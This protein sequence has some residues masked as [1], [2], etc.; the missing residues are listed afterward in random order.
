MDEH[1]WTFVRLLRDPAISRQEVEAQIDGSSVLHWLDTDARTEASEPWFNSGH[2]GLADGLSTPTEEFLRWWLR[3]IQQRLQSDDNSDR[4]SLTGLISRTAFDETMASGRSL[5]W[6]SVGMFDLDHFKQFNDNYGHD[7]GDRVLIEVG[8]EL[9]DWFGTNERLVR[10]GGEEFLVLF[11]D[12]LEDA[13][14]QLE[15]FRDH[16][17]SSTL[18]EDQPRAI[19]FSGGVAPVDETD[20]ET[21]ITHADQ[22]LYESKHLGRNQITR[23]DSSLTNELNY[24]VWGR[25]RYVRSPAVSMALDGTFLNLVSTQRIVRYRWDENRTRSI[26]LP[27]N[28][29]GPVRDFRGYSGRLGLVDAEGNPWTVNETSLEPWGDPGNVPGF[30]YLRGSEQPHAMAY[31][32]QLYRWEDENWQRWLGLPE[33]WHH[34]A[35]QRDRCFLHVDGLL[36]HWD[37]SGCLKRWSLPFRLIQMA[38][39][40]AGLYCLS[41]DGRLHRLETETN[42]FR[43]LYFA[44]LTDP[45]R[46]DS[47]AVQMT[48]KGED[49]LLFRDAQSRVMLTRPKRK[50]VAQRMELPDL[51]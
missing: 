7:M 44:N 8:K 27:E 46:V 50:A 30:A 26:D 14:T 5:D 29:P 17:A 23:F 16:L 6:E 37:E 38:A 40:K 21:A 31:N 36:I 20:L 10:Y 51:G 9:R 33:T 42:R 34:L 11:R 39:G 12:E 49:Q 47:F 24:Y 1:P 15:G 43:R 19:T 45:P 4:D 13:Y 35:I 48:D 32:N 2:V 18:F 22:A 3:E 41:S 28:F 25:H